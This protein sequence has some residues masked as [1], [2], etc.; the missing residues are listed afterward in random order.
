MSSQ[1]IIMGA[2]VA[3]V[4][5]LKSEIERLRAENTRLRDECESLRA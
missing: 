1:D 5:E 3:H 2:R 4:R